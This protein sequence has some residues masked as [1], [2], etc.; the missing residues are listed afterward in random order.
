MYDTMGKPAWTMEESREKGLYAAAVA[1]AWGSQV[2]I[3]VAITA[4]LGLTCSFKEVCLQFVQT[5]QQTLQ[6]AAS[7][8]KPAELAIH[9][10]EH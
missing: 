4:V 1:I 7:F 10:I 3:A 9:R 6:V 2:R 5:L 8:A